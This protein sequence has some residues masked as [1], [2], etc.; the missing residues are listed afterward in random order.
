MIE[1]KPF[2]NEDKVTSWLDNSENEIEKNIKIKLLSEVTFI[3]ERTFNK[4]IKYAT[5]QFLKEI[6]SEKYIVLWDRELFKSKRWVF[7]KIRYLL[8]IKKIKFLNRFKK[9]TTSFSYIATYSSISNLESI[10]IKNNIKHFI[11]FD[12]AIYSGTQILNLILSLIDKLNYLNH[13]PSTFNIVVG[14]VSNYAIKRIKAEFTNCINV[15]IN[16]YYYD[17][18]GTYK[19]IF[20]NNDLEKM[21][22]MYLISLKEETPLTYFYYKVP[23]AA[24]FPS[25]LKS[26]MNLP[27]KPYS[28]NTK[29]GKK[30]KIEW[31]SSEFN[32][33]FTQ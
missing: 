20:N 6:K 15:T 21:D 25:S 30:E 10:I 3:D 27:S 12:D 26:L 4:A 24:S 16:F 31:E 2:F 1:L 9:N 33:G 17:I 28:K 32:S 18:M 14:F 29:Y 19:E 13:S 8:T 7:Y 23:D 22:Q 5:K 11:I